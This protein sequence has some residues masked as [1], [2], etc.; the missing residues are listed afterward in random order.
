MVLSY[1]NWLIDSFY[2]E[3]IFSP[4]GENFTTIYVLIY[5]TIYTQLIIQW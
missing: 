3:L 1:F 4:T 2:S 5:Q